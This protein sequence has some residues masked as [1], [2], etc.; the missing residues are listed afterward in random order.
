[1]PVPPHPR[2]ITSSSC[3]TCPRPHE[4]VPCVTDRTYTDQHTRQSTP[5]LSW[6]C[7]RCNRMQQPVSESFQPLFRSSLRQHLAILFGVVCVD[8]GI[9]QFLNNIVF[10]P[11]NQLT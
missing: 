2:C 8:D 11:S 1:M 5:T 9:R 10:T 4:C 7:Q 6:V 3:Q